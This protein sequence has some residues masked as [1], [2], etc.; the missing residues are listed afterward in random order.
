MTVVD[1]QNDIVLLLSPSSAT[2]FSLRAEPKILFNEFLLRHQYRDA[3]ALCDGFN[4]DMK[5]ECEQA[6]TK[7]IKSGDCD[8]ALEVLRE[9]KC[10]IRSA[11][12]RLLS[13][14]KE[15]YALHL[16]LRSPSMLPKDKTDKIFENLLL[17]IYYK[18]QCFSRMNL[19]LKRIVRPSSILPTLISF[20][21]TQ[22]Y[23]DLVD[24][25]EIEGYPLALLA[26]FTMENQIETTK[27][28]E[29]ASQLDLQE[30]PRIFSP[31][32]KALMHSARKPDGCAELSSIPVCST[33]KFTKNSNYYLHSGHLYS[34]GSM[35][36]PLDDR[37]YLSFEIF[38]DRIFTTDEKFNVYSSPL[39][40]IKFDPLDCPQTF[41]MQSDSKSIVFLSVNGSILKLGNG[42]FFETYDGDFVD[43][44]FYKGTMYGLDEHGVVFSFSDKSKKEVY[45]NKFINAIAA[46][47][48]GI[49][50]V[51]GQNC[52]Y[53]S[54]E[55]QLDF[56]PE[57][58]KSCENYSVVAGHGKAAIFGESVKIITYSERIGTILDITNDIHD[59]I[60]IIGSSA[61]PMFIN[62]P[63]PE[64]NDFN[65]SEC[66]LIV[67]KYPSDISLKIVNHACRTMLLFLYGKFN[68]IEDKYEEIAPFVLKMDTL[69]AIAAIRAIA[70]NCS[71]FPDILLSSDVCRTAFLQHPQDLKV[72]K[73]NQLVKLLPPVIKQKGCSMDLV[74]SILKPPSSSSIISSSMARESDLIAFSCSH[75][76]NQT[77]L[78]SSLF[79]LKEFFET[80]K[81]KKSY[82]CIESNYKQNSIDLQCP[83]CLLRHLSQ[84]YK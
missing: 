24:G 38:G 36:D 9:G 55:I 45:S 44:C 64:F 49:V 15:K 58:I 8:S 60:V 71:S 81:L 67:S 32:F 43:I 37:N 47:S 25:K 69:N 77:E 73:Q 53:N 2:I 39:S 66:Q 65:F 56:V 5:S 54:E 48:N 7:C 82:Q 84:K 16:L 29:Y 42:R 83:R 18:Q 41:M 50:Y 35:T 34:N 57:V 4:L 13:E 74:Q 21:Q 22:L 61:S 40:N 51:S 14:G 63:Q 11:L 3:F 28:L 26:R 31:E 62:Q 46:S 59:N 68:E 52:I 70:T 27:Y 19:L 76:M 10:E 79:S 33:L 78:D 17:K 75:V 72:L 23:K 12:Q 30:M 6:A 20:N 80:A 1:A